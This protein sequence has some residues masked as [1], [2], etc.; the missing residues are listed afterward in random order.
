MKS[1]FA[2][3]IASLALSA[4]VMAAPA[5]D[6]MIAPRQV[7]T[8]TSSYVLLLLLISALTVFAPVIASSI[9][10]LTMEI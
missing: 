10:E 8:F 2:T 6:D 3:V 5:T 1:F 7:P 4:S 9:A